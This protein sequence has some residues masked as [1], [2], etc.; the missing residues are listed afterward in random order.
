ML[1]IS[2]KYM[3][4]AALVA[5]MLMQSA[6]AAELTAK[7]V[8]LVHGAFADGSSWKYV[9]P[10]LQKAGLT[11]H[12]VQ[13]PLSSLEDDVAHT[14]RAI[15]RAEE[16]VVLVGHSW[17]GVVI[18]EAGIHDKVKSLVY[19]AAYAPSKGQSL[20]DTA[21]DF[22]TPAGLENPLV[23]ESGYIT[24]SAETIANY[25]AQ[26]VPAAETAV[27]A[28]SQGPLNSAA[29][30]QVV[31]NVAWEQKPSWYAVSLE[32]NMTH[33]DLQKSFVE[34]LNA[35]AIELESSHTSML[36]KPDD[37]AQ[38]IIDAAK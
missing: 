27:M 30:E 37:I 12:S 6:F 17:G 3:P 34:K 35:T 31:T 36:S 24:L 7:S 28:T 9:I 8:V 29:L 18:T 20:L 25:F 13:N 19:V 26:D 11:V 38:L 10:K 4:Y 14:Q 32:D 5:T 2:K 23:D 33:T 16:P 1:K 22:P 21:A 15:E